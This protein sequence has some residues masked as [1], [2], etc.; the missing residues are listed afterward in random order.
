MVTREQAGIG[1]EFA[2]NTRVICTLMT[3]V[4]IASCSD[5]D[6]SC[7]LLQKGV[8]KKKITNLFLNVS[9]TNTIRPKPCLSGNDF[10]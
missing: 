4:S 5:S 10:P 6:S 8:F 2:D 3:L 7:N 9:V 1:L